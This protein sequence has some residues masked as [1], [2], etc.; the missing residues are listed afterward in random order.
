MSILPIVTYN[1]PILRKKTE[2]VKENTPELQTLIDNMLETMYNAD[3]VGLAAPQVG[4]SLKLFVMDTDAMIEEDE[5]PYGSMVFINPIILEKKGD[6]ISM[7]EGCLSIP[8]VNDKVFRP[9][10]I[11]IEYSDRDF[12]KQRL[13]AG[14]WTSRVIQ[15]EYDHLEGVLFLDHLSAF[16]KRLH[17]SLLKEINAGD[18]KVKYPVL[19]K[20]K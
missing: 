15:H 2:A 17:K 1:D 3:G 10:T 13:E 16:K 19:P 20:N 7:E 12:N 8:E 4:K 9:E 11:V 18:K 6:K 5:V 14:G